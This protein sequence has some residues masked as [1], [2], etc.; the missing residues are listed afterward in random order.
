MDPVQLAA[1]LAAVIVV[2][3]MISVE[4]GL[5]HRADLRDDSS[6][7]GL[8]AGIIDR[9]QFSLLITVVV[10]S[11]IL[12]TAVPSA[13]SPPTS[14]PNASPTIGTVRSRS[15]PRNTSRNLSGR[16]G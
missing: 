8:Q 1:V 2:A 11:A 7:Y 15:R 6:L 16:W 14:T 13:G 5:W 9:T 3:S 12:P 10:L 4:L